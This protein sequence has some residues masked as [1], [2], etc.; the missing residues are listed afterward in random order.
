MSDRVLI[1]DVVPYE[2]PSSLVE[3]EGPDSG[4]VLLPQSVHWG[5]EPHADLSTRDGV[6]KAYGSLIR[7]G[8]AA[9]QEQLLN[10]DL[11]LGS[12]ATLR[13]P[14][15]CRALWKARFPEL[16]DVEHVDS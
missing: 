14:A 13:L 15:R 7:E 4:V 6:Q 8:T 10:R 11:L 1:Q 2:T 12:W 16:R 5:P 3:L 9:Q